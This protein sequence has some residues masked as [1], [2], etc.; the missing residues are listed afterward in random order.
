MAKH[1]RISDG[2]EVPEEELIKCPL[3]GQTEYI[4]E[5]ETPVRMVY[6][7]DN[8]VIIPIN[9]ECKYFCGYCNKDF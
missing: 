1:Y 8:G 2:S 9:G 6:T 7:L 4:H 5:R 3:C